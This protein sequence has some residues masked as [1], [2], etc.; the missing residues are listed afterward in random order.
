MDGHVPEDHDIVVLSVQ[1]IIDTE[2]I[3]G[4]INGVM[5]R[6]PGVCEEERKKERKCG[7]Y[8]I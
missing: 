4:R 5:N 6:P 3:G 8:F 2:D 1:V 7:L